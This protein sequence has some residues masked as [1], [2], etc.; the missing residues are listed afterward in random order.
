MNWDVAVSMLNLYQGKGRYKE[1]S[2]SLCESE[3][4]Q[5]LTTGCEVPAEIP[6]NREQTSSASR[7][8]FADWSQNT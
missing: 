1:S 6:S 3:S 2:Q 8:V 7:K 4:M 5:M